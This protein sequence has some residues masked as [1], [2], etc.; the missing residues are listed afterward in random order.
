MVMLWYKGSVRMVTFKLITKT[1]Q[2]LTYYYYPE[3]QSQGNCGIIVFDMK[4][5]TINFI[6]KADNDFEKRI[7]KVELNRFRNTLVEI[8]S[9]NEIVPD[10]TEDIK[11]YWYADKV[12]NEIREKYD[13]GIILEEGM[14]V[15]Y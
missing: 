13:E 5:K 8:N 15:W 7:R 14:V 6:K 12:L 9:N 1:E 10:A 3:G 11:Y 2:N 4:N